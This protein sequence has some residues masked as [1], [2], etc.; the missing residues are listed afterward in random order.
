MRKILTISLVS[1]SFLNLLQ[2]ECALGQSSKP[3]LK[4]VFY[5]VENFYDWEDDPKTNDQ[6]FLPDSKRHWTQSRFEDKAM[7]IY[8][9]FASIGEYDFPTIIGMA[10]IENR[11]VLDYLIH[12]T[13]MNK[14]QL[15]YVHQESP[16]PR[17]IDA[18]ML[19][20]TDK[21]KLIKKQFIKPV[22]EDGNDIVTR[23]I[24]YAAFLT[25]DKEKLHVFVNH[26]PSRRGGEYETQDKRSTAAFTLR[27]KIDSILQAD[28]NAKIIVMGDFND[29]PFSKSITKIL[30][31]KPINGEKAT[32]GLYNLSYDFLQRCGTGTLKFR[33]SWSTFDQIIVSSALLSKGTLHTCFDCACVFNASF[34]LS[35]DK[36]NMGLAPRRTYNGL[37]YA[38]GYSDHLP[39]FINLYF[40]EK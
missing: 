15:S 39:V 18:C 19:Y 25:K 40:A 33:G 7:N 36:S 13:P 5:N 1:W 23:D 10:E 27:Q 17:G 11:Y 16:D 31:A 26:W 3:D 37:K 32:N 4:A 21:L 2:N 20:R 6:D 9:V 24:V 34:L 12:Q 8:K 28:E 35:E 29:E 14:V 38:G 22:S 30:K